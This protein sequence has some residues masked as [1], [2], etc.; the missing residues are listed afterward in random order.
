MRALAQWLAHQSAAAVKALSMQTPAAMGMPGPGEGEGAGEG[1]AAGAG[2]GHGDGSATVGR[3]MLARE[4]QH[5]CVVCDCLAFA[6][7]H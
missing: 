4:M 3:T 6:R 1:D 2:E 7:E 5:R